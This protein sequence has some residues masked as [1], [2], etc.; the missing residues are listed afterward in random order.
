MARGWR[1]AIRGLLA[2]LVLAAAALYWLFYDNR[3]PNAGRF[4]LDIAAIRAEASR[5]PGAKPTRIEVEFISEQQAPKIAMVAGT[6]WAKINLMRASYRIVAPDQ[7][8]IIDTAYDQATAKTFEAGRY[9][10]AAWSRM[11]DAMRKATH[12]VVTHEHSDHIGG[13][14]Q[15]PDLATVLPKA[16]LNPEQFAISE[17]TKP[18][19]WPPGSRAGYKPFA[20][21]GVRAIAPGIVLI[22]ARGH[23]P[24]SQMI[25]VERADGRE[26]L[27]MGDAASMADNVALQR[28]RS[29]LVTDF[30]TH[31]AREPVMLQ[32]QALGA[33][34]RAH[35]KIALI[36]GHDAD[37]VRNYIRSGQLNQGFAP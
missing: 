15:H 29:R 12:I 25:Y 4:D 7:S 34:Q 33:L 27:F 37:A 36:P 8:T 22:R 26:Y 11:I 19:S 6:D 28:I 17:H 35:P 5:L 13:L 14:M 30:F 23:T 18:V 3:M 21:E 32:T 20:Y 24:G 10:T 1:W 9:D 16:R 31:E 2:V